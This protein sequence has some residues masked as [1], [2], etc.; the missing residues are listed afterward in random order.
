[1]AIS[2]N[3]V[4][5]VRAAFIAC[6]ITLQLYGLVYFVNGLIFST[7]RELLQELDQPQHFDKPETLIK[8]LVVLE[9]QIFMLAL[10]ASSSA[11]VLLTRPPVPS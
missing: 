4:L 2:G 1:M 10:C 5:L 8:L 3:N 11:V 6:A 7:N 9:T